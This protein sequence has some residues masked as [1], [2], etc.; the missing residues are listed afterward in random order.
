[1]SALRGRGQ[2][3]QPS[4]VDGE[5]GTETATDAAGCLGAGKQKR[6]E[7]LRALEPGGSVVAQAAFEQSDRREVQRPVEPGTGLQSRW[8]GVDI[9]SFH[10]LGD[11][12]WEQRSAAELNTN[13]MGA[14]AMDL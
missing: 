5:K 7:S 3:R 9:E 1:M 6:E 10:R 12:Q 14:N 11:N 8:Q 2:N 13:F 4:A